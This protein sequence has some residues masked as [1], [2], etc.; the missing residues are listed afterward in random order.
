MMQQITYSDIVMHYRKR[1]SELFEE[2]EKMQREI[3]G[4]EELLDNAWAGENAEM[5]RQKLWEIKKYFNVL[6]EE[7]SEAQQNLKVIQ[8]L[9]GISD[10]E[11]D[12]LS[13]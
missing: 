4:A 8:I 12:V 11:E 7:L 5:L 1:L 9:S 10:E 2:T 13:L 6:S 3:I